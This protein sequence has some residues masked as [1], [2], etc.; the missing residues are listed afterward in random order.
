MLTGRE[1]RLLS[2]LTV[3]HTPEKPLLSADFV[4]RLR[5]NLLK[6]R[7]MA[8]ECFAT[9]QNKPKDY[10]DRKVGGSP[11]QLEGQVYL[12]NPATPPDAREKLHKQWVGPYIVREIYNETTYRVS[13][14][15]LQESLK[16][17]TQCSTTIGDNPNT[18]GVAPPDA[19]VFVEVW[20][21]GNLSIVQ[22]NGEDTANQPGEQCN[23]TSR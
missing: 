17:A 5:R 6:I 18:P 8:G 14:A 19:A 3:P 1:C 22:D 21:V 16:P 4:T 7:Q 20:A 9:A 2:G 15:G 13:R 23:G 10:Y 12:H 11:L